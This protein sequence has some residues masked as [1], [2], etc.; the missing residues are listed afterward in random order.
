MATPILSD[1]T[2]PIDYK[3]S[4]RLTNN[5][6]LKSKR[7]RNTA[8]SKSYSNS[9]RFKKALTRVYAQVNWMTR[10]GYGFYGKDAY[11]SEV[12]ADACQGGV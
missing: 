3:K 11:L 7:F 1:R 6:L 5:V 10:Q 12:I 9:P 2:T 4:N 8:K